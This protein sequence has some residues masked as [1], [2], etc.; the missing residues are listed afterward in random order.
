MISNLVIDNEI[1]ILVEFELVTFERI[2]LK[3]HYWISNYSDV[4]AYNIKIRINR[5]EF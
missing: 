1:L 5:K 2:S 3:T 4:I